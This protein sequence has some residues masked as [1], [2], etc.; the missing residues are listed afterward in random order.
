MDEVRLNV[1]HE[2]PISLEEYTVDGQWTIDGMSVWDI[3]NAKNRN[4]VQFIMHIS[5][6]RIFYLLTIMIPVGLYYDVRR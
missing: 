1:D 5:R 6:R 2:D 4:R 3:E